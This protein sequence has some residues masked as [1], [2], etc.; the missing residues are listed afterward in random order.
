MGEIVVPDFKYV[1]RF[2]LHTVRHVAGVERVLELL[3]IGSNDKQRPHDIM[4]EGNKLQTDV[5]FG[6]AVQYDS[7][8]PS[9]KP[10]DSALKTHRCG[11]YH[12][13]MWNGPNPEADE[14][15]LKLGAVDAVCSMLEPRD[16]QG[17]SHTFEQIA[18]E[19]IPRNDKPRQREYLG[20]ILTEM[21]KLELP[22]FDQLITSLAHRDLQVALE[23]IK[24]STNTIGIIVGRFQDTCE[25]L[26]KNYDFSIQGKI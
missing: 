7:A 17:G 14:D 12:H 8:R 16:Y 26:R 5:L 10:I 25:E 6:L 13:Q 20:L 23:S 3:C 19:I 4:G 1:R 11:Q 9:N 2:L 21:R 24:L 15:A 22:K 18:T